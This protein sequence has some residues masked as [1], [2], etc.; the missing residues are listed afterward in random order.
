MRKDDDSAGIS[1]NLDLEWR[2]GEI[3]YSL[4]WEV[5]PDAFTAADEGGFVV[6][7]PLE[8]ELIT[9]ADTIDARFSLSL[10]LS[11]SS[12]ADDLHLNVR[13]VG[14][15]GLPIAPATARR[16]SEAPA[17]VS[18]RPSGSWSRS[19]MKTSR[20]VIRALWYYRRTNAAV[21]LGVATA[22]AVLGGAL[23]VGD[24]VRGSLRD[25]V[26][27]SS[28]PDRAG[29]HLVGILPRGARRRRRGRRSVLGI[30][31]VDRPAD[32]RRGRGRRSGE[33]PPRVARPGVR[34]GRAL[35]AFSRRGARRLGSRRPIG[36]RRS[37]ARR[38]PTRSARR[39]AAPC[40]CGWRGRPPCRSNRCTDE[41]TISGRTLRL[42]VQAIVGQAELGEFSLRPQQGRVRAVFVPLRRLQQELDLEGRVNT[43]LV[44]TPRRTRRVRQRAGASARDAARRSVQ[45]AARRSTI[46]A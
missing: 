19:R 38:S 21:V 16:L 35:L 28:R 2:A 15:I 24:S 5:C 44:S 23:L 10:S 46:W 6:T 31:R 30:V 9:E 36:A 37:S 40:W 39:R 29:R 43:L 12:S 11:L 27:Q 45:A 4:E 41:R 34:R 25:L 20:L 32:H 7:S 42:T 18:Y 22:V 17:N 1:C 14:R 13:G 8:P 3:E 26:L 33:R